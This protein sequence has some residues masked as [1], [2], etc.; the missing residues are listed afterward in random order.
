MFALNEM[1]KKLG[2]ELSALIDE[3]DG[4]MQWMEGWRLVVG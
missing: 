2:C 1:L 4:R 3:N